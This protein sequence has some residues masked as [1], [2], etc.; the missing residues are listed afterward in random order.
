MRGPGEKLA[1]SRR[2]HRLNEWAGTLVL[3]A[4]TWLWD[5]LVKLGL[6]VD[7]RLPQWAA[8]VVRPPFRALHGFCNRGDRVLRRCLVAS[9]TAHLIGL[10]IVT[11]SP[12]G[13]RDMPWRTPPMMVSLVT[14]PTPTLPASPETQKPKPAQPEP[15]KKPP[16]PK[17]DTPVL[18]EKTTKKTE[19]QKE[20]EKKPEE[21]PPAQPEPAPADSQQATVANDLLNVTAQVDEHFP[22][23][24]YLA[25][26]RRKIAQEWAPPAGTPTGEASP[27]AT[28]R[29]RID[30]GGMISGIQVE[31]SSAIVVYDRSAHEALVRAQPLPPLPATY[32]GR[33]LTV[34]LRFRIADSRPTGIR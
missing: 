4:A 33:W 2:L 9:G 19:P 10:L 29:F 11:L 32:S 3:G 13:P 15:E 20:P 25:I 26:V 22:F 1:I 8:R 5:G 27:M 31:E 23:D 7:A 24:Y 34:H 14:M 16:A 21:K 28:M 6:A 30:R 18:K 17:K 12:F